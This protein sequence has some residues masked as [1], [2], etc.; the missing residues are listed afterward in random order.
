MSD[1]YLYDYPQGYYYV[2]VD[3]A[4]NH[5]PA[6]VDLE[7][8]AGILPH[9]AGI[10]GNWAIHVRRNGDV[11]VT[12]EYHAMDES[13]YCGWRNFRFTL[14]RATK[15][16]YVALKGPYEGRFQVTHI[17]GKVY[18]GTFVSGS[19]ASDYLDYLYDTCACDIA[20]GM[21]IH[22]M[23]SGVIASSESAAREYKV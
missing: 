10:D 3:Y 14:A 22:A 4:P 19:D 7:K 18:L 16:K 12:G 20:D 2:Y 9:G 11:C 8:L 21:D 6:C 23:E 13:G 17:R 1:V 5:K 15:N